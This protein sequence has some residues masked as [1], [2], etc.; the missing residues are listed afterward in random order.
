MTINAGGFDPDTRKQLGEL[1]R[2]LKAIVDVEPTL[3]PDARFEVIG[4]IRAAEAELDKP[5]AAQT[6]RERISTVVDTVRAATGSFTA[7]G[8]I[9]NVLKPIANMVGI[10]LP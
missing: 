10:S 3:S 1:L 7:A 8:I 9:Y 6:L 2:Q 5:D 4:Q